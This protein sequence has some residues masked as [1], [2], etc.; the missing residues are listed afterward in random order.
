M[1]MRLLLING[2]TTAAI[3]ERCAA[4]ARAAARPGTEIAAVGARS[5]P[6]VIAT[7]AENALATAVVVELFAEHGRDCDAILIA[8]S[9]DTALDAVREAA[10]VPVVGM[11]EAALHAAALLGGRIGFVGPGE[12]VL[13]IYRE[14]VARTGLAGRIAGYRAIAMRPQDYLEPQAIVDQAVAHAC[15]L[16]GHEGAE[17]VVVAGAALAGMIDEI[18]AR[19]PVPVVDGIGAGV[20]LAEALVS[21]RRPKATAGSH[22]ILMRREIVGASPAVAALFSGQRA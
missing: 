10:S 6:R 22:S 21:L 14:T 17:T 16:V 13:A 20:A 5:G 4:A 7:R 11:T 1:A 12:R 8:V 15:D 19:V 3:T 2:N 9:F 18:Q